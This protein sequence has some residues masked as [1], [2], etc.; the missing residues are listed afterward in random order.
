MLGVCTILSVASLHESIVHDTP[1]F[2]L[3]G[4]P[5]WQVFVAILQISC[6]L[7]NKLSLQSE[8]FLHSKSTHSPLEQ[9]SVH[10]SINLFSLVSVHWLLLVP[11]FKHS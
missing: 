8:L 3:G 2:K 9:V 11:G 1:S 6:P 10:C 7:Q 5:A 4:T